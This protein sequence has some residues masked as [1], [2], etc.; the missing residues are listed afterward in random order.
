MKSLNFDA[1]TNPTNDERNELVFEKRNKAYGA[2]FLRK[3]YNRTIIR[4]LVCS[5]VGILTLLLIPKFTQLFAKETKPEAGGIV[6]IFE[7]PPPA[8]IKDDIIEMPKEASSKKKTNMAMQNIWK[9][10]VDGKADLDTLTVDDINKLNTGD[11]HNPDGNKDSLEFFTDLGDI[12]LGNQLVID[13]TNE[14]VMYVEEM[15]EFI[16]GNEMIPPYLGSSIV[17]PIYAIEEG[18]SARVVV[19]FIVEKDGSISNVKILSCNEKGYGFEKEAIR[20]ISNMPK[21]KPGKQNGHAARVLF[22]VP[23]YFRLM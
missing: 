16:G 15:P 12:D 10:I 8:P 19:G 7:M 5:V 20:V 14:V 2:Y 17:Y 6:C 4:A 3:N 11:I 9:Q 13:K 23:I 22:N 21:W 1:W 18:K